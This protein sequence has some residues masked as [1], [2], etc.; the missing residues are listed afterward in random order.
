MYPPNPHRLFHHVN[1][2]CNLPHDTLIPNVEVG[3]SQASNLLRFTYLLPIHHS[4]GAPIRN[5]P[6]QLLILLVNLWASYSHS[7]IE[8][9]MDERGAPK[10]VKGRVSTG[11]WVS[12]PMATRIWEA[13]QPL[14]C[15]WQNLRY[16]LTD[17]KLGKNFECSDKEF[18]PMRNSPYRIASNHQQ[19]K[20]EIT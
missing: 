7:A 11:K 10:Y 20:D 12:S 13:Q 14:L 2:P 15:I 6:C 1:V 5:L 18:K 9:R 8:R 16:W 19:N 4:W 17:P 3:N